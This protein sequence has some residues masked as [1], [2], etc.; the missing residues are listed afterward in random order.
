MSKAKVEFI[1]KH[2]KMK[3]WTCGGVGEIKCDDEY[4]IDGFVETGEGYMGICY[5]CK[6]V[7]EII[8]KTCNGSK[9]FVETNYI[10]VYTD[11]N[12]VKQG[13]MVDSIK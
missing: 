6:G 3:C 12:G 13:F 7:R 9:I 5:K 10:L 8:C 4:C 1:P 11:K 2:E